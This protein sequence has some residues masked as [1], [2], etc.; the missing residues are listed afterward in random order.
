[1]PPKKRLYR[2]EYL[3]YGFSYFN[4]NG[5]VKPRCVV[6]KKILSVDSMKKKNLKTHLSSK[7]PHLFQKSVIFFKLLEN[8]LFGFRGE[9]QIPPTKLNI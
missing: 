2:E 1:M 4:D 6:C 7:H 5:I 3:Q 8:E 9:K